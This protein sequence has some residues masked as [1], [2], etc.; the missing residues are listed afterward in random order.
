MLP[1]A[2]LT[3]HLY[4]PSLLSLTLAMVRELVVAPDTPVDGGSMS[5]PFCCHWY[6][7]APASVVAVAL[8]VT[9]DPGSTSS[10]L[11]GCWVI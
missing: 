3:T 6:V 11:A 5:V 4:I 7:S 2:L 8:N 10:S 1:A 9:V